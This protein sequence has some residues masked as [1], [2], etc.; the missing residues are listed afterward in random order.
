M[1]QSTNKMKKFAQKLALVTLTTVGFTI[2]NL[3]VLN[4]TTKRPQQRTKCLDEPIDIVYTWVNGSDPEFVRIHDEIL[5]KQEPTLNRFSHSKNRYTDWGILR[6][7]LRSVQ[8]YAPW[9]RNVVLVTN[10]QVPEWLNTAKVRLVNHSEIMSPENLPTFNSNAIEL[11]LNKIPDL[12]T[13]FLYFN[14]DFLLGSW[15]TKA[16]FCYGN[17]GQMIRWEQH[18]VTMC[19]MG[20][21][22]HFLADN[23]CHSACNNA[24]CGFD[25]GDC[26]NDQN[27]KSSETSSRLNRA[28]SYT[29]SLVYCHGLLSKVYGFE[30]R[31]P[32]KHAPY[33]YDQTIMKDLQD[34]FKSVSDETIE[35]RF[36][37]D[38]DIILGF[39]YAYFLKN[40]VDKS[41]FDGSSNEAL[42][43]QPSGNEN[44]QLTFKKS[45]EKLEIASVWTPYLF[46]NDKSGSDCFVM[47]NSNF[48]KAKRDISK[49]LQSKVKFI[50][51]N[52]D[53]VSTKPST[54]RQIAKMLTEAMD[55]RFPEPSEFELTTR[56]RRLLKPNQ[57]FLYLAQRKSDF[58][59]K[60]TQN[61]LQKW[62]KWQIAELFQ[63][64]YTCLSGLDWFSMINLN[65]PNCQKEIRRSKF[66]DNT[67]PTTRGPNGQ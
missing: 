13:K 31:Y 1:V 5:A 55:K 9:V 29:K 52:D 28:N 64:L 37:G 15:V 22:G 6:Y 3:S 25:G 12:S 32:M 48:P 23:T 11:S 26:L 42:L 53:T 40:E 24:E 63:H 27:P 14:D 49:C 54:N 51:F 34:K 39:M 41:L 19:K 62:C 45:A 38:K 30:E 47:I 59:R 67:N 44:R 66:I 36:R 50:C 58:G 56:W 43:L 65:F 16:D 61:V 2:C 21:S 46:A 18:I 4:W 35:R 10:G 60:P 20:C 17:Q 33:F 7:S 57:W 8:L